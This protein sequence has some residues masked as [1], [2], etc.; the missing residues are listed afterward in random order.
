[1]R[2]IILAIVIILV[3]IGCRDNKPIE[4]KSQKNVQ[5]FMTYISTFDTLNSNYFPVNFNDSILEIF[6]YDANYQMKE[7]DLVKY[8]CPYI[9]YCL[10]TDIGGDKPYHRGYILLSNNNFITICYYINNMPFYEK[11]ISINYNYKGE[12][13]DRVV[14]YEKG[15]DYI[16]NSKLSING[17]ISTQKLYSFE[18]INMPIT[19][20]IFRLD[21]QQIKLEM[22]DLG[23]ISIDTS[24]V[25]R[26][27]AKNENGTWVY[28]IDMTGI[29]SPR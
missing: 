23:S 28:P 21:E 20:G 15:K 3:F 5:D 8:V 18:N 22:D 29:F 13:L 27:Y 12:I 19:Q 14:L 2:K 25:T 17:K 24:F 7:D 11:I 4:E 16:I 1:M 10:Y 26:L 6:S 9:N